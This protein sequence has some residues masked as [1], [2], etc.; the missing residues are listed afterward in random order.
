MVFKKLF[1]IEIIW[2]HLAELIKID[3]NVNR[4]INNNL[5]QASKSKSWCILP[6]TSSFYLQKSKNIF[7]TFVKK[8]ESYELSTYINIDLGWDYLV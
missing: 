6:L 5:K 1:D 7:L 2:Y 8:Q 3:S 4:K